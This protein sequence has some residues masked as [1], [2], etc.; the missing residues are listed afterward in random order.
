ME[1]VVTAGEDYNDIDAFACALAYKLLCDLKGLQCEVVLPGPLNESVSKSIRDWSFSYRTKLEGNPKDYKYIVVDISDPK[2]FAKFVVSENIQEVYDH[3]F[4]FE[5]FW[6]E[7]LGENAKIEMVGACA[8]LIW[9]EFKRDG[10]AFKI[11]PTTANLL[12]TAI[13]SNTLN[14]KASVTTDRDVAALNELKT[15]TQLPQ[16]WDSIYFEEITEA[17]LKEP[18]KA[19]ANDTKIVEINGIDYTI[20]QVELWN[21]KEF[22][23]SNLNL[24][25]NLLAEQ[26]NKHVFLT[27][28]SI[29]EGVNYL[30]TQDQDTK[31]S[32]QKTIDAKFDGDLGK[33]SKLW[34][35]K[36]IMK[37]LKLN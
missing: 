31:N 16:E 27:S 19:M 23:S 6:K 4:G 30:V 35:R 2:H 28:P 25:R 12:Y 18:L 13:L 7:K 5:T 8:T 22:I 34:L 37:A 3:R 1:L 29:S 15:Y 33:T 11:N 36:E 9:E 21:S 10:L 26:S 17:V 24:I 20:I 32:L 14:L